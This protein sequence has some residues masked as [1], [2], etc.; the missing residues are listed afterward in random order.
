MSGSAPIAFDDGLGE[1]L[2]ERELKFVREY[3]A[4]PNAVRAYMK[5]FGE[6][7][8]NQARVQAALLKNKPR[9]A[10]EIEAGFTAHA[11]S[12]KAKFS[13]TIR[14]LASIAFQDP[15]AYYESDPDNG[16]L[17]KP[18]PWDEIDP[19]SRK[20]IC[21]VKL[22]RK[23]LKSATSELY[24]VE[25]VEYKFLDPMK[26]LDMLCSHLGITKGGM[27]PDELRAI[28]FGSAAAAHQLTAQKA[29]NV[30][31]PGAAQAGAPAATGAE[32]EPAQ[33]HPDE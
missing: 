24:E 26:A 25:E 16:G 7:S 20:N 9:V 6:R 14:K 12:C 15:D 19:A 23:R 10:T 21:G 3:V 8:Y 30:L 32:P 4:E 27:T 13:A 17:P 11:R 5:V 28:I 2:T 31:L 18:K 22:K 33:L 29:P 1:Q